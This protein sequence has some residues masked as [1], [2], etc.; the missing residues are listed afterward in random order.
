[1]KGR[2]ALALVD[3][4]WIQSRVGHRAI[5]SRRDLPYLQHVLAVRDPAGAFSARLALG[6]PRI[7]HSPMP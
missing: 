6:A 1:M 3:E 5:V 7:P 4:L 2:V